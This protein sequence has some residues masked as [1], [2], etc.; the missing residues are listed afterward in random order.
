MRKVCSRMQGGRL[1]HHCDDAVLPG[2]VCRGPPH[3]WEKGN[4]DAG[5]GAGGG[6]GVG[7]G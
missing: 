4:G 3:A 1:L 7:E 6:G 5:E 2:S